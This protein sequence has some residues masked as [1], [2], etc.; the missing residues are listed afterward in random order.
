[1]ASSTYLQDLAQPVDMTGWPDPY[2]AGD[3][4]EPI[5]PIRPLSPLSTS[6][7]TAA[8][9]TSNASGIAAARGIDTTNPAVYAPSPAGGY[10]PSGYIAQITAW[11]KAN[12][13]DFVF[14][15]IGLI[16]IGAA[17]FSFKGTQT[18]IKTASKTAAEV[19]A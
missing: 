6:T 4:P 17:V 16:L 2:A 15:L 1:M 7:P 19:A 8:A 18:V 14:I 3:I 11:I 12:L 9:A 13:E 10:S 5:A